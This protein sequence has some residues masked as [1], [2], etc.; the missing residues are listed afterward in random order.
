MTTDGTR[1]RP[2]PYLLPSFFESDADAVQALLFFERVAEKVSLLG[3]FIEQKHNVGEALN[4]TVPDDLIA[5]CEAGL[6]YSSA[7]VYEA[8]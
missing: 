7:T 1:I 3:R 4:G 6:P 8:R 2:Q 5:I